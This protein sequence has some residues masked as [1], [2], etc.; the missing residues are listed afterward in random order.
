MSASGSSWVVTADGSRTLVGAGGEGYK[1]RHGALTEALSVYL[2]GSGVGRRLAAGVR[3]RVLEVGFGAG[4][5][6]L[7]T[8]AAA[9]AG[10]ASLEY[11]ALELA[12]PPARVLAALGYEE[13]LAPSTAPAALLAWRAALGETLPGGW[14]RLVHD[15]VTLD[16]FVGDAVAGGWDALPVG[17]V[18]AVYHDAFSPGTEPP[19]W[20]PGF[21]GRLVRCLAPG[22][23]LVSFTVAG[24][25]RRALA[26]HGLAVERVPGPTGGK[27]QVLLARRQA[28]AE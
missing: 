10:G 20:S 26:Q 2:A 15:Q 12:P 25:V 19:L 3:T 8:A 4:L 21:L 13:L 17:P 7:V 27:R 9:A 16:L 6:F 23:A 11:L 24:H 28:E 1:S 5:N 18:D 22:G 14:H